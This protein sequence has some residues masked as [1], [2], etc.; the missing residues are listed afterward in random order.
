MENRVK[1]IRS[2]SSWT[3]CPTTENPAD[4]PSRGTRASRLSR[5]EVWFHGPE[6]L[7]TR[8]DRWPSH[9]SETDRTTRRMTPRN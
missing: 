9:K 8:E 7:Q 2:P 3:H 4:I 6:W 5:R 1:E